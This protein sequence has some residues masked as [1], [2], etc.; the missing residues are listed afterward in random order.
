MSGG[1]AR[2]CPASSAPAG[3]GARCCLASPGSFVFHKH[4]IINTLRELTGSF[5][6]PSLSLITYPQTT[7][8][9]H[10]PPSH[11]SPSS[12]PIISF[13]GTFD[14]LFVPGTPDFFSPGQLPLLSATG[15]PSESSNSR[16]E[17]A[18]NRR[19]QCP[20]VVPSPARPLPHTNTSPLFAVFRNKLII[21]HMHET[22]SP[23]NCLS[24]RLKH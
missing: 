3:G 17:I 22:T 1:G 24:N 11:T 2:S 21:K 8:E 20:A 16:T 5:F 14:P 7:Y 10:P 12:F 13:P 6:T 18:R 15:T 4:H 9:K 19:T 23:K